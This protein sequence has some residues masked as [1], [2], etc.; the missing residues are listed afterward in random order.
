[1]GTGE[2]IALTPDHPALAGWTADRIHVFTRL[3]AD[4]VGATRMDRP[5]WISVAPDGR[6]YVCCT[7]NNRRGRAT[8]NPTEAA[9][10]LPTSFIAAL[11]EANPRGGGT[12]GNPYGQILRWDE[13]GDADAT[14]FTWDI[15][16]L[17]GDPA[18]TVGI[19]GG[20]TV[21]DT[22]AAPDAVT[23]GGAGRIWVGTDMFATEVGVGAYVAFKNNMLLAA[24][25]ETR[26][27]RRFL[28]GPAGCEVPASPSRR[29][30]ARCSST[31]ST[32]ASRRRSSRPTWPTC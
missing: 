20:D 29:T 8:T 18:N 7:N 30:A 15:L 26:E 9:G 10:Q 19:P 21:G 25:P 2:W 6:T 22:F 27:F 31:S 5:E 24:D 17:A 23:V 32:R 3:A 4:A 28:I 1:M 11:D 14:T 16:V 13:D 12:L